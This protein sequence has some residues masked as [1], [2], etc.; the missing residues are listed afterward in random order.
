M[1]ELSCEMQRDSEDM[2]SLNPGVQNVFAIN[3]FDQAGNR[4]HCQPE[5]VTI[6]QGMIANAPMAY[7]FGV[8]LASE[9][10]SIYQ[11]IEGLERNRPL[12]AKG[13]ITVRTL[14]D[15]N[16]LVDTL[17]FDKVTIEGKDI[18][19][20]MASGTQVDLSIKIDESSLI[21]GEAFIPDLDETIEFKTKTKMEIPSLAHLRERANSAKNKLNSFEGLSEKSSFIE[22]EVEDLEGSL[23]KNQD[24]DARERAKQSLKEIWRKIDQ[25]EGR[26]EWPK[27]EKELKEALEYLREVESEDGDRR[28]NLTAEFEKK[29]EEVKRR[30]DLNLA[31]DLQKEIYSA[32]YECLKGKREFWVEIIE[33][34][35]HD[36][37][38]IEWRNSTQARSALDQA[39]KNVKRGADCETLEESYRKIIALR[40]G[41]YDSGKSILGADI[42]KF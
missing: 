35:Q 4:V 36:F 14:Q 26:L 23:E 22:D 19:S 10:G 32:C 30:K 11:G 9:R 27:A 12:P 2:A 13:K 24:E 15:I 37:T 34:M 38:E 21:S 20:F 7:S 17:T 1:D 40:K 3:L 8:A 28:Q 18:P 41:I 16:P 25:L 31:Q 5:R 29:F 6:F 42:I 33:S 39:V